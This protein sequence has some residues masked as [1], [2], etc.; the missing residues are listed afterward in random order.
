MV[1]CSRKKHESCAAASMAARVCHAHAL[2]VNEALSALLLLL[3]L[4]AEGNFCKWDLRV[5]W[6]KVDMVPV[7]ELFQ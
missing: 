1:G 4:V 3:L 5:R 6:E 2:R 7:T